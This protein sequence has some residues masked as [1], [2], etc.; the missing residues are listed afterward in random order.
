MSAR[1][2]DYQTATAQ[3]RLRDPQPRP[4]EAQNFGFTREELRQMVLELM[5]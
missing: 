4:A 5:G 2:N 1:T 3:T